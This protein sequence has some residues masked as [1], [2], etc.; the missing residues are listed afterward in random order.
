MDKDAVELLKRAGAELMAALEALQEA[1]LLFIEIRGEAKAANNT[2]HDRTLLL[3]QI[4]LK[5]TSAS[6]ERVYSEGSFFLEQAGN[7]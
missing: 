7:G 4:G 5:L 3:A 2:D 6:S 1:N